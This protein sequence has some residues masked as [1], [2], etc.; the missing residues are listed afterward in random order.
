VGGRR[1]RP[2][3]GSQCA[4]A[5]ARK[6]TL[7]PEL[8]DRPAPVHGMAPAGTARVRLL[9]QGRLPVEVA[10]IDP[11]LGFRQRFYLASP[12]AAVVG[13]VA[14]DAQGHRLASLRRP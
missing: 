2:P 12:D 1:R 11:G 9:L 13:V 10:A 6:I 5:G 7:N 14:L 8:R 3:L 4:V